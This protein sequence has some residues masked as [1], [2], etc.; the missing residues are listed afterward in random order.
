MSSSIHVIMYLPRCLQSRSK[1]II[2]EYILN[3][4]DGAKIDSLYLNYRD[5]IIWLISMFI[6]KKLLLLL[7][8]YDSLELEKG[9]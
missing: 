2:K 8:V 9:I 3:R 1:W 7:I 4:Y 5:F 6:L